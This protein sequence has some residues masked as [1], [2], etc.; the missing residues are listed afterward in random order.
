[1]SKKQL[2]DE[3]TLIYTFFS[4]FK[5]D[6]LF[7]EIENGYFEK[8]MKLLENKFRNISK[9]VNSCKTSFELSTE[10][11]YEFNER[12]NKTVLKGV[13]YYLNDLDNFY[14]D[15]SLDEAFDDACRKDADSNH[16]IVA[17]LIDKIVELD[18]TGNIF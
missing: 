16:K 8:K 6:M 13:L 12:H 17:E 5:L 14:I 11:N 10:D 4:N 3:L 1:M 9:L 15:F 7:M 18:R 2:I